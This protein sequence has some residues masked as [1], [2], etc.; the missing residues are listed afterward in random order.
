MRDAGLAV[1]GLGAVLISRDDELAASGGGDGERGL[2]SS[3]S[4]I[5]CVRGVECRLAD[6]AATFAVDSAIGSLSAIT[7]LGDELLDVCASSNS[8]ALKR[9]RGSGDRFSGDSTSTG[10]S[11]LEPVAAGRFDSP[12]FSGDVGLRLDERRPDLELVAGSV[13]ANG[14][15][16]VGGCEAGGGAAEEGAAATSGGTAS[17]D[18][19]VPICG[20]SVGSAGGGG[21][22]EGSTPDGGRA[23][24][25]APG[26][27]GGTR[28][29][30][31]GGRG[32]TGGGAPDGGRSTDGGA[33]SERVDV[34]GNGRGE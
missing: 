1:R 17:E 31:P 15:G 20:G 7:S 8:K 23:A 18:E 30:A 32:S 25:G 16:A 28:G 27:N 5:G 10:F 24:G 34:A 13:G 4:S 14:G 21:G 12:S 29:G 22:A 26:G 6:S 33:A 11:A 19:R 9:F 2:S 3:G